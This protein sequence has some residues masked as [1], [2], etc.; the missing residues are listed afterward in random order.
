[1]ELRQRIEKFKQRQKGFTLVEL[2]VVIAIIGIL[3]GVML[4]KYF[5]FTDDARKGVAISEAK[6]IRTIAET[7][8]A[9]FGHWPIVSGTSNFTVQTGGA[10]A[11]SATYD[12][13]PRFTGDISGIDATDKTI[14]NGS[15]TYKK[16]KQ[17]ATCDASGVV[18]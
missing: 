6:S 18:N 7:Y 10:A 17:S 3:A 4:P 5:S 2:I 15:F 1:M 13:S 12:N 16:D 8:Y 9:T 14:T 11:A